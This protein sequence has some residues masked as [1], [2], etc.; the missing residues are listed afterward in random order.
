MIFSIRRYI[1]CKVNLY[2]VMIACAIRK[3]NM[4]LSIIRT[5]DMVGCYL[6][7]TVEISTVESPQFMFN[8]I[9]FI[10]MILCC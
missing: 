5:T 7:G 1:S 4:N 8:L 3:C 9:D 10:L 6:I 2:V